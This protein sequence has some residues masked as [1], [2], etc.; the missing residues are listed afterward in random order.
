VE[1]TL[2]IPVLVQAI[3]EQEAEI[4]GLRERL[5]AMADELAR[6]RTEAGA[7]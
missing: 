4:S 7:R 5:D 1:Y 6:L 2:L 3:R